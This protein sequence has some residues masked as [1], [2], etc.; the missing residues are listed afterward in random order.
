LNPIN[1][2]SGKPKES[3]RQGFGISRT[4]VDI[5]DVATALE[6][7]G[8][9][10]FTTSWDESISSVTEQVRKAGAAV[11]PEGGLKPASGVDG[12]STAPAAAAP[13][14]SRGEAAA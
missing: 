14:G 12:Q 11:T 4:G 2:A 5:E 8:L 13:R 9:A 10:S 3:G 6:T 7:Q 1:T